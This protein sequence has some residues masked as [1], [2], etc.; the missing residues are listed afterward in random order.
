LTRAVSGSKTTD[1]A[2]VDYDREYSES[3]LLI[4]VVTIYVCTLNGSG[5]NVD[6][7]DLDLTGGG[8]ITVGS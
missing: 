4:E 6:E 2:K 1:H 3:V 5:W 8:A 7:F